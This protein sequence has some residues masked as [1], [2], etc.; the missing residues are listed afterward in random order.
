MKIKKVTV[1]GANGTMGSNA[2]AIF[3]SFGNAT[4]YM[5]ARNKEKALQAVARVVKAVKCES[6]K[7]NLIPSDYSS[8]EECIENSDLV[9][10]SV[11]EDF[12]I[13]K[14]VLRKVSLY[15][16]PG[17]ICCTGTSGLSITELAKEL[18]EEQRGAFFGMHMFNPPYVMVLCEM[19][20]TEYSNE[21]V[22]EK[23]KEYAKT[24]LRRQVVDVKDKPGFLGNRIGFQFINQA[25]QYAEMY[26]EAGGIDYIDSILGKCTGR[27][28]APIMTADFVGLDVHKAIV[29]YLYM[30]THDFA[31]KTF[32]LPNYVEGLIQQGRLGKK[33]DEG[34]YKTIIGPGGSRIKY[35]YDIQT[36]EYRP[37]NSY[38]FQFTKKMRQCI[39]ES[40]YR[41]AYD[42]LINSEDFE[43]RLCVKFLL[44]YVLYAITAGIEA[45]DIPEAIDHV[46]V[47]GFG[48]CPPYGIVEALGGKSVFEELIKERIDP[49]M[50]GVID[51][52]MILDRVDKSSYDFRRYIKA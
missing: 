44:T 30:N 22:F 31:N 10:E 26:K 1:L 42:I 21:R 47:T 13:K 52:K 3:A 23:V 38:D 2:S 36:S 12:E 51:W 37:V 4:V 34:F 11:S 43:P 48:W 17:A 46:M 50:K 25:I 45:C 39:V 35:V 24:T 5:V 19:I 40:N 32:Q 7:R 20:K 16:K 41:K 49:E 9:F 14:D 15:L 6:I 8:L 28:M 27:T 18:R 29:D 33:V